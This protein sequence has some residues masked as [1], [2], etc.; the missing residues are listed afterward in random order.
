VPIVQAPM[1]GVS[2]PD[3]ASAVSIAGALGSVGIGAADAEAARALIRAVR[4][5]ADRPFNVDVFCNRPAVPD[6]AREAA[7]QARLAPE[8]ARY[9]ARPPERRVVPATRVTSPTAA[10]TPRPA[11]RRRPSP[12]AQLPG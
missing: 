5:G 10:G 12:Q 6:A 2:T 8:F 11:A 3:M 7:W 4:S 9:A 1:A